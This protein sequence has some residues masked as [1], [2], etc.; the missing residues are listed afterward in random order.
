MNRVTGRNK[1]T[2]DRAPAKPCEPARGGSPGD[3]DKEGE[4]VVPGASVPPSGPHQAGPFPAPQVLSNA[5]GV[6]VIENARL[7][8]GERRIA[9]APLER[10]LTDPE[11][12]LFSTRTGA[13]VRRRNDLLLALSTNSG[14]VSEDL[15]NRALPIRLEPV[16][17]VGRRR[18]PIGNPKHEYLPAN[19]DRIEAEL[20]GMI[21]RWRAEGMPLDREVQHPFTQWAQVVGG[22][23]RA[24]GFPDFLANYDARKT[25]DDPVKR[26]LALMGA[27]RPGE[28]VRASEWAKLAVDLGVARAVLPEGDRD[29]EK[30]RERGIGVVLT[31]HQGETFSAETEAQRLVVRLE[32]ARRRFEEGEPST[33]YRF[34]VLASESRPEDGA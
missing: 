18:S 8:P 1:P 30:G 24:N 13:P 27:A 29:S 2:T 26:A 25:L 22:I 15:M 10:F 4:E 19:R 31:A 17:D 6:V 14:S 11:P 33:R 3:P 28:W 5:V 20:R 9:S 34:V 21:E 7:G 23:L 16:G 12:F 32:R